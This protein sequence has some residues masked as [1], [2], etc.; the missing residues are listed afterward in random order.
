MK[1]Q[2]VKPYILPLKK[3]LWETFELVYML[4]IS[5]FSRWHKIV[6][7]SARYVGHANS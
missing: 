2:Q 4:L 3:N 7:L 1:Y 5:I 6:V